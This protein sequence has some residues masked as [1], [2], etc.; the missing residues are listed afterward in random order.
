[1][2]TLNPLPPIYASRDCLFSLRDFSYSPLHRFHRTSLHRRRYFTLFLKSASPSPVISPGTSLGWPN[3]MAHGVKTASCTSYSTYDRG[4]LF[5][6][7]STP[8]EYFLTL[9]PRKAS[10]T[11]TLLQCPFYEAHKS[12]KLSPPPHHGALLS[13]NF[14]LIP[15]GARWFWSC[16]CFTTPFNHFAA[17][18]KVRPLS[19]EIFLK[20]PFLAMNRLR[21]LMNSSAVW[22]GSNSRWTA[23]VKLQANDKIYGFPF[24]LW[25]EFVPHTS[26][27]V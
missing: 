25:R 18:T 5:T 7:I 1:M 22:F 6:A 8:S 14:H 26:C 11:N 4:W 9:V 21:C 27:K 12:L 15:W 2:A 19:E 17:A 24:F 16:S 20:R 13:L 23:L 10:S 3:I